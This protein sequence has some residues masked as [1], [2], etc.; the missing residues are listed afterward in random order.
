MNMSSVSTEVN[1]KIERLEERTLGDLRRFS[2]FIK[3][4]GMVDLITNL[5]L[6]ANPR[7]AKR[8]FVTADIIST[9]TDSP[10]YYFAKSKGILIGSA[11]YRSVIRDRFTLVI[12]NPRLE[13]SWMVV[14]IPLPSLST[15]LMMRFS[16]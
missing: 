10:E 15:Y 3:V 11:E 14:T 16:S 12:S 13:A 9:I 1:V 4:R 2:G 7:S 5:D 8:S 6:E